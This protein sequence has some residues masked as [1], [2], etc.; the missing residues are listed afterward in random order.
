[1][2]IVTILQ[3]LFLVIEFTAKTVFR[4]TYPV[5][6]VLMLLLGS[7]YCVNVIWENRKSK[8]LQTIKK[9]FVML[10]NVLVYLFSFGI[11][12]WEQ[13]LV[14]RCMHGDQIRG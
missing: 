5:G 3:K 7:L 13:K 2:F 11:V 9:E 12:N 10:R 4:V 14:D 1:M 6:G 8:D